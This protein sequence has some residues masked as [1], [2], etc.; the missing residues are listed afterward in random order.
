MNL[1]CGVVFRN[2]KNQDPT[3]V[4]WKSLPKEL[5]LWSLNPTRYV[6]SRKPKDQD[7]TPA[8]GQTA[9]A[10]AMRGRI[11]EVHQE[12]TAMRISS[13]GTEESEWPSNC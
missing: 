5:P 3:P 6:T 12:G 7:P 13:N 9:P 2:P 1:A 11:L 4:T 10:A 8:T